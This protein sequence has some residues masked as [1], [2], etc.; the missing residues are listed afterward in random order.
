MTHPLRKVARKFLE[1][2]VSLIFENF[3]P[4]S[5]CPSDFRSLK[6]FTWYK[7]LQS[8]ASDFGP[9]FSKIIETKTSKNIRMAYLYG[10]GLKTL[11]VFF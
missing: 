4:K 11:R 10:E 1:V 8:W 7:M 5:E 6:N 2:Q 3:E 9:N